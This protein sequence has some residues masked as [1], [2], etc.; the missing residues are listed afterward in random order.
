MHPAVSSSAR[1]DS[2]RQ[3]TVDIPVRFPQLAH[4]RNRADSLTLDVRI[5]DEDGE[6]LRSLTLDPSTGYQ[7]L[8][9]R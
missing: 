2:A 9:K 1:E 6:L 7:G 4:G 3:E 8:G 5:V